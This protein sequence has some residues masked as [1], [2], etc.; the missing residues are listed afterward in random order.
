MPVKLLQW[1][2]G[3]QSAKTQTNRA[4]PPLMPPS[5]RSSR[6]MAAAKSFDG[7][8]QRAEKIPGAP[9]SAATTKPESSANAGRPEAAAA[10]L[11][12]ARELSP[13]FDGPAAALADLREGQGDWDAAL[14]WSAVEV[15]TLPDNIAARFALANRLAKA[16]RHA[17]AE[18]AYRE[19]LRREPEAADAWFNLGMM[20]DKQARPDEAADHFERARAL[21]AAQI[22]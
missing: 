7:P 1:P 4:R 14:R 11:R 12:R 17:D 3:Q 9:P 13:E 20:A 21:R 6:A 19:I 18:A 10:A 8:P 5:A 16:E 15:R 22:R 2:S